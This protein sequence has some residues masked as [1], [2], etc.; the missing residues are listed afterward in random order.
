MAAAATACAA[1][2]GLEVLGGKLQAA[3]RAPHLT[4]PTT[5][6]ERISVASW[7]FRFWIDSPSNTY[8]DRSKPGMTL[9]DFP[10]MVVKSSK[11]MPGL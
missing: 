11:V 4:F 3:P 10:A 6:R 5:P 2:P 1:A 7:P 9:L 8:R